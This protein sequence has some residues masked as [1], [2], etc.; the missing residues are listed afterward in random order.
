[1]DR[2][3]GKVVARIGGYVLMVTVFE[4][5]DSL[6]AQADLV[7][8]LLAARPHDGGAPVLAVLSAG[9]VSPLPLDQY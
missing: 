4:F 2:D 9:G 1:M 3:D 5:I 8:L 7:T 6:F